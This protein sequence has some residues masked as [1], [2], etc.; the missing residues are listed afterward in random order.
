MA[1][2]CGAALTLAPQ[3][4]A[5]ELQAA[6]RKG[7]ALLKQG[8][9]RDA[10]REFEKALQIAE[11]VYG[12]TDVRTAR[13]CSNLGYMY[14]RQGRYTE[15]EPLLQ[16]AL[17]VLEAKHGENHLDVA[18][19]LNNLA[20]LYRRQ[21][22]YDD[23]ERLLKRSLKILESKRGANALAVATALNNLASLYEPRGR[24]MEMETLYQRALRIHESHG[25]ERPAFAVSLNN[26]A[27]LYAR[28]GRFA[29]AEPLY[30]RALKILE[31]KHGPSH[32]DV[33]MALDNLAVLYSRQGSYAEAEPLHRRALTI[34][35]E[36]H[37]P[38]HPAVAVS[39]NNL[40]T[41]YERQGRLA[42][43]VPLL[44][45]ALR[46]REGKLGE[47]HAGVATALNNL[48][49]V[50]ALQERYAE[51]EPLYERALRIRKKAGDQHRLALSLNNLG[52][53]YWLQGRDAEAERLYRQ[54]LKIWEGKDGTKHPAVTLALNNLATVL[55]RQGRHAEAGPL[56]ERALRI[57]EERFD[58][59]HP[60]VVLSRNNL[61]RHYAATGEWEKAAALY[62]RTRRDQRR[63]LRINLAPLGPP[64][65][66]AYLARNVVPH[67]HA[68]L[69]FAVMRRDDPGVAELAAGWLLNGKGLAQEALAEP[70][71]LARG[72]SSPELSAVYRELFG[73]RSQA[74]FLTLEVGRAGEDKQRRDELK[75]VLEREGEL[76]G[77]LARAAHSRPPSADWVELTKLR[78]ALPA[79]TV[80][81]DF[82]RYKDESRQRKDQPYHYLACLVPSAGRGAVELLDLGP[83]A[84]IEKAVQAVRL[85]L[86]KSAKAIE[87]TGEPAAEAELAATRKALSRLL[88]D[89]LYPKLRKASHWVVGPDAALWLVPL[90]MLPLPDG[91]Y[92][93]EGHAVRYVT[94][95]RDLLAQGPAD[96]EPGPALVLADPDYDGPIPIGITSPT[97]V[98][99]RNWATVEKLPRFARLP[100]TA[101]EVGA[102]VPALRRLT[103]GEPVV[104]TGKEAQE[105]V[106][107]SSKRPRVL[108]LSTHGYFLPDQEAAVPELF[109]DALPAALSKEG[110][111]LENPLLR[112]GLALA[113][114]N[115][116]GPLPEGTDDGILT[117]LEVLGCDLT[118]TEL[119]VLSACDTGLGQV[120]VGD[121]VAGLRQAFH[122][123][124]AKAVLASLWQVP[125]RPTAELMA[126]FFAELERGTEKAEALRQAKLRLIERR[127]ALDGA[128]HPFF[129]A[130]FTLT[131]QGKE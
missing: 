106:V 71:A 70:L 21:D 105:A 23:A 15:A 118:G 59:D 110:K 52:W 115:R 128:A 68:A 54:A 48:A 1:L 127:R 35:E 13:L 120:N 36:K 126:A 12:P 61:A 90:E 113:G 109:A 53:L 131:V 49:A 50:Y 76:T 86:L 11:R 107:K 22:R 29:E 42:E 72:K 6:N 130:A 38:D 17:R 124:G 101:S 26:M 117:G 95:G 121:G 102:V 89:P 87:E 92:V 99:L 43:A 77:Q 100:G 60:D 65:Q 34:R 24:F 25:P 67:Y 129:W 30:R 74:A 114:A 93:V 37:G 111:P 85:A 2:L 78:E 41:L 31:E 9:Y 97:S 98:A 80:Y 45:R 28:Q 3:E 69:E 51:A 8:N 119:V 75:R 16:R 46:I 123:A 73:V 57:R 116:K 66:L 125:D 4:G 10:G 91:R 44:E 47:D 103:G 108:V 40:A 39:L 14:E 5:K 55:A 122:V 84:P 62:Q 56:F 27:S 18:E 20:V 63:Q 79:D 33:A 58:A 32:P 7:L 81:V 19:V 83:A 94:S 112:C 104:K 88:L 82:A 64:Q 96:V